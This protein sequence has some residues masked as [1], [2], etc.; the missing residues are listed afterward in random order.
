DRFWLRE[1]DSDGA[2]G[3]TDDDVVGH[4]PGNDDGR[5]SGRRHRHQ[6]DFTS[7]SLFRVDVGLVSALDP[8]LPPGL[9]ARPPS[10]PQHRVF[11]ERRALDPHW[12]ATR[13]SL[14]T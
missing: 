11:S 7:E 12:G 2:G 13:T 9:A 4:L 8:G 10:P 1:V 14:V 5:L 6:P 3:Y